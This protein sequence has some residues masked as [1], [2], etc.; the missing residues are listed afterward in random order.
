MTSFIYRKVYSPFNKVEY[1]I[2]FQD[3]QLGV[4]YIVYYG[5][6]GILTI[7]RACPEVETRTPKRGIPI[8]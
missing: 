4:T 5:H 2:L 8:S 3:R 1:P 7:L 6:F